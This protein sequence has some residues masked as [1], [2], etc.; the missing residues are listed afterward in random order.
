[1]AR[2]PVWAR[3]AAPKADA[4][5]AGAPITCMLFVTAMGAAFWVGAVWASQPWSW[6]ALSR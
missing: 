6:F 1:M 5:G 4:K 2:G 3:Q